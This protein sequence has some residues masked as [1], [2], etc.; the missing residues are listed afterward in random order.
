MKLY[1]SFQQSD[2]SR[3][4]EQAA[5]LADYADA[6]SISSVTLLAHGTDAIAQFRAQFPDKLLMA[7]AKI[8]E[9]G[10]DALTLLNQV[11][12]NWVTAMAGVSNDTIHATC[13]AAHENGA[14]IM[15]DLSDTASKGQVALEAKSL[16]VDALLFNEPY[17]AED[18]L[19]FQ[20][21]WEMVRGNT[22]LPIFVAARITREN[23]EQILAFKPDGIIIDRAIVQADDPAAEAKFFYELCNRS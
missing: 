23:I 1:I 8:V 10:K 17:N 7:D 5:L 16:G 19:N 14:K 6:F 9:R 11:G 4:I 12:A 3:A 21:N 20:S 15:L 22:E 2:V 13:G 18:P